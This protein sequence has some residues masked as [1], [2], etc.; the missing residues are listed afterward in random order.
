MLMMIENAQILFFRRF[1]HSKKKKKIQFNSITI[2][3]FVQIFD[4]NKLNFNTVEKFVECAKKHF[5]CF[6]LMERKK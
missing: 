6:D 4:K 1:Y 5:K 2:A 3:V